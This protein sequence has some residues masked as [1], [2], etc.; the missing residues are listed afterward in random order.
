VRRHI[1]A[2][3]LKAWKIFVFIVRFM[4][5]LSTYYVLCAIEEVDNVPVLKIRE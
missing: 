5:L 1:G 2:M 3:L 4:N